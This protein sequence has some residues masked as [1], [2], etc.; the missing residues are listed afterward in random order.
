[1]DD[2][3][4][5]IFFISMVIILVKFTGYQCYALFRVV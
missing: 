2:D 1:M 5:D 4:N 3:I